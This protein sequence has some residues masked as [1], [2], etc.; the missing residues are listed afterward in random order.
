MNMR[1][2]WH[3]C[4]LFIYFLFCC[5]TSWAFFTL[6]ISRLFSDGPHWTPLGEV[7]SS[8]PAMLRPGVWP[9]RRWCIGRMPQKWRQPNAPCML[10]V[11]G[12]GSWVHQL[13]ETSFLEVKLSETHA[14]KQWS[15]W[16]AMLVACCLLLVVHV[17]MDNT[18]IETNWKDC[19]AS[20]RASMVLQMWSSMQWH[21]MQLAGGHRFCGICRGA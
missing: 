18:S 16:K 5:V 7:R 1:H 13:Q 15:Q 12:D 9:W 3:R 19:W 21:A 11:A 4:C 17:S 8:R 10:R 20:C 2:K 6:R 14:T